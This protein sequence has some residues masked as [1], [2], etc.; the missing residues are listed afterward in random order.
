MMKKTGMVVG[1]ALG[2]LLSGQ[3][4]ACGIQGSAV[5]SDGSKIDGAATVSTTWNKKEA[6]PGGGKYR[7]GLGSSACGER[8]TVLL[9]GREVGRFKVDGW[10]TVN[11]VRTW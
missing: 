11:L 9:D 7:L 4:L 8:I 3:A 1:I 6:F 5:N 2:C 10:T